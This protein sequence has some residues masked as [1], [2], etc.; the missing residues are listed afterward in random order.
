MMD[1]PDLT[2]V[3]PGILE[4]IEALE[5][6]LATKSQPK[7]S[8]AEV[9]L[10]PSEPPTTI[11]I[12]TVSAN[13]FAKRTARHHYFRQRRGGMG[14]F[15]L[16]S[17]E[18]DPPKFLLSADESAGLVLITDQARAF[19][20]AV[21]QIPQT[22]VRARGESIL[23]GLP[24]RT[25]EQI[26]LLIPNQGGSHVVI[27]SE[28]GQ[29]RRITGHYFGQNLKPGTLLY[30]INKE[31]V[32]VAACWTTGAHDLL[33]ATSKGRG[34]RFKESQVPMRGC[35][36]MR[37]DGDDSVIGVTGVPE[38]GAVFILTDEGKGTV[39]QMSGFTANK[40]PGSGG[41]QLMKAEKLVGVAEANL[42]GGTSQDIFAISKLGKLIRF[43][44][45]EVPPKEGVVQG[46]NCM[47]LRADECVTMTMS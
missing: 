3:S 35:L 16:D 6:K 23:D 15:D 26:A 20:I 14:I 22:E 36:G 27:V 9:D 2:N 28:R 5:A 4:Y 42:D 45:Y 29:V 44:T 10:E 7:A 25:D 39:R 8:H 37:L 41:K 21:N 46:V 40:S 11:N 30:D 43:Q 24:L 1:R 34:I 17:D 47:N 13:G 18:D 31:G 33:I 32:P 38:E 12:I 19:P